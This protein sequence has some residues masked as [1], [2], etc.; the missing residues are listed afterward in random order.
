MFSH[1]LKCALKS[2]LNVAIIQS[3]PIS[4][5]VIKEVKMKSATNAYAFFNF[6]VHDLRYK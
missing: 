3:T 1:E 5:I 4:S 6:P 2:A